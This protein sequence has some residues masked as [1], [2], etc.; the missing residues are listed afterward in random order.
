MRFNKERFWKI[1]DLML[2]PVLA[3]ISIFFV[4]GVL[5]DYFSEKTDFAIEEVPIQ[6]HP[7]ISLTFGHPY[8]K[9]KFFFNL[10][11][12]DIYYYKVTKD[13]VRFSGPLKEG[14][15]YLDD[16]E[17][18]HLRKS[19]YSYSISVKSNTSTLNHVG[20]ERRFVKVVF[21]PE[22]MF[23]VDF[24]YLWS[25][26]V[27]MTNADDSYMIDVN[28]YRRL[29]DLGEP[30]MAIIRPFMYDMLYVKPK[31]TKLLKEKTGCSEEP[32]FELFQHEFVTN[33]KKI[34]GADACR[35]TELP[36]NPIRKCETLEEYTCAFKAM[37][38]GLEESAF[39][40]TV[41]CSNIEYY[42]GQKGQMELANLV[43]QVCRFLFYRVITFFQ[44]PYKTGA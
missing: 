22:S 42:G 29:A 4:I 1:V 9:Y 32:F 35:P 21:P 19:F 34:C 20:F 11:E 30:Y 36:D 31:M 13:N 41:P 39:L 3:F 16:S 37:S 14:D 24:W 40:R 15:N 5:Q 27:F 38:E 6:E 28:N 25:L 17:V 44:A 2:D 23:K 10:S 26:H 7:T 18:I 43:I 33:V 8:S 12:I